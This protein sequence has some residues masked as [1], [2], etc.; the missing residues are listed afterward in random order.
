[1]TQYDS[2]FS[3]TRWSLVL[4]AQGETPS[5]KAAL[6]DLCEAYYQ[7]VYQFLRRDGH[8]EDSA[9]DLTQSF[10]A[11]LLENRDL[12][13]DQSRGRFRSYILGAVKHFL[14][15]QR[16]REL[17]EKRGKGLAPLSL[18]DA[19]DGL[20]VEDNTVTEGMPD[21]WFDRQWAL[22]V[23]ARGLA[24]VESEWRGKN[25][26]KQ[27]DALKFSLNGSTTK[28]TQQEAAQK[29]G[30]T[31]TATK[32]AIHRLRK[33]F[34]EVIR[35]EIADTIPDFSDVETEL[36]Y[37]I[38]TLKTPQKRTGINDGKNPGDIGDQ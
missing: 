24:T 28:A 18:A 38:E 25:K 34:G 31:E 17:R 11:R 32:V 5:A 14:A 27:F 15:D 2:P 23:M 7:P 9:R 13:A 21:A 10:F 35:K 36:R 22:N 16:K 30:W 20:T 4:R 12:N 1:M 6:S 37:L 8:D 26:S 19:D 33:R 29:L 3:P